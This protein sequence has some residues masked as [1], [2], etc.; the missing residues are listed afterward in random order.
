MS[1]GNIIP[2]LYN[3]DMLLNQYMHNVPI[4]QNMI[5]LSNSRAKINAELML[6][7]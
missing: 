1:S 4:S 3:F 7:K 2:S 6:G 5:N